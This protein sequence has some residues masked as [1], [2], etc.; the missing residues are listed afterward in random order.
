M[1]S[2]DFKD[3]TI[4]G[5]TGLKVG[6]LGISSSFGAEAVAYEAA[7]EKGCNYFT[8]GTFVKGRSSQMKEAIQH[9]VQ[10]G[11]RDDLVI[12]MLTYAHNAFLTEKFFV[13]GIKALGIEYADV[14]ILGYFPKQPSRKIMEGAEKLKDKGL[15]RFIG[16]SSHNRKLFPEIRNLFDVFHLRYNAAHTGAETEAFPYLSGEGS[17]GLVSFT[18]TRWRQLLKPGK[19]P[20]GEIPPTAADCYR[21]V[22]SNPSIHVCMMGAGNMEQM[23]ENLS[24]LEQGVMTDDELKRMR[25]IGDHVSG[26]RQE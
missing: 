14:L 3:K 8:W 15:V 1:V 6:R 16:L 20:K 17:P 7:F 25:R 22:L 18:A 5:K 21:F 26:K 10:K 13:R 12:A 9:I 23:K 2:M 19:M 11:R 24:V 4:L